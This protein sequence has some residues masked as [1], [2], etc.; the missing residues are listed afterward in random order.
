MAK[1]A[2]DTVFC[3]SCNQRYPRSAL[4]RRS[5]SGR[6]IRRRGGG[7]TGAWRETWRCCPKGHKISQ[8]SRRVS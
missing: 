8:L 5:W 3:R 1:A 2:D 4:I 7:P 6:G